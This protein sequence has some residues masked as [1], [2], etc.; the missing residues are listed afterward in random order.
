MGSGSAVPTGTR[1]P[2]AQWIECNGRTFLIDCGEGTQ[3]RIREYGLKFQKIDR[4]FITHLHG[5]HY[6][7]LVGL[8]STIHMLGR[9]RPMTIHGPEG[10]KKIV[11]M[12]LTIGGSRLGYDLLIEEIAPDSTSV[13]FEDEK[14][15]VD[16]FPLFHKI[17]TNG[18]L[19][20]QKPRQRT[21]LADK[22][23]KDGI[24]FEYFHR[25]KKGE[26][27]EDED[28]NQINFREYT[29]P[30]PRA[31]SYA[32]CSDTTYHEKVV[33]SVKNVDLLYHEATFLDVHE[34][35]ARAT[36]HST[37]TMAAKVAAEANVGKLIMGHLS[38]RY[39]SGDEHVN[40]AS[41]VFKNCEYVIDGDEIVLD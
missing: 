32:Y 35:R 23:R 16:A 28:G 37:A 30:P 18:F 13:L 41:A 33:E 26:D 19:V 31:K 12:Q 6:F 38:A 24:K 40:E 21:L 17:P 36:K 29:A 34:D 11:E 2:S 7:G 27:V 8:L 5:D 1:N 4:I 14:I 39:D 25:L 22:A 20:R 10:L 9:V 3:M 15:R